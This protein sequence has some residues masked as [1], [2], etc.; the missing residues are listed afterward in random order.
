MERIKHAGGRPR[1][2][3][4][5][6]TNIKTSDSFLEWVKSQR[7]KSNQPLWEVCE[8]LKKEVETLRIQVESLKSEKSDKQLAVNR[9][10]NIQHN[11]SCDLGIL[12]DQFIDA[13]P[14]LV[15]CK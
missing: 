1:K 11:Q 15:I 3:R 4:K 14:L 8:S 2:T 10:I 6:E 5:A 12:E 7:K 9:L 13:E